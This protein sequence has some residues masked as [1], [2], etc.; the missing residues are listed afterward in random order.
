MESFTVAAGAVGDRQPEAL[1]LYRSA[2]N[3]PL[4]RFGVYRGETGSVCFVRDLA[5]A[6]GGAEGQ[7][8]LRH[9]ATGRTEPGP[10]GDA[11]PWLP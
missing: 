1:E 9:G 11:G 4:P 3:R 2:G 6:R 7:E 5:V 10:T 8:G